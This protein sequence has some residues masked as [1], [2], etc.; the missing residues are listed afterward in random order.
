MEHWLKLMDGG[1]ASRD[2]PSRLGVRFF[3]DRFVGQ[4][5]RNPE[6]RLRRGLRLLHACQRELRMTGEDPEYLLLRF[7]SRYFAEN[8]A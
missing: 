4:M 8:A 6:A 1:V 5:E 2:V 7:L 3:A